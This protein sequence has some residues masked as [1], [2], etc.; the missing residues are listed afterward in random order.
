MDAEQLDEL[1]R[2]IDASFALQVASPP[3]TLRAGNAI[4]SY[5]IAPEFDPE[6]D[7]ADGAYFESHHFG[8]HHLDPVSWLFYL[9]LLL[10][11]SLLQ[12]E[13]GVSSA[14]DTFLFSLRPPDRDPPRFGEL[15]AEQ[16]AVVVA[17]LEAIGYSSESRYQDEAL[18]A[19]QEYWYL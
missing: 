17:V 3:L 8:I 16:K 14:V 9:P 10:K 4:D 19:L 13:A 12:M 15:S 7:R 6:L 1:N 18:T 2:R 5:E 11:Y